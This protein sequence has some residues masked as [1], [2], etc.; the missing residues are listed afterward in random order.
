MK[1]PWGVFSFFKN[2]VSLIKWSAVLCFLFLISQITT[3]SVYKI[4]Q[5]PDIQLPKLKVENAGY[6]FIA[7]QLKL[8]TNIPTRPRSTALEYQAKPEDSISSIAKKF[9]LTPETILFANQK[10]EDKPHN[11]RSD[12]ILIIPPVDGIYY[13]WR[14]DDTLDEVSKKF[15]AQKENIVN[16]TG[17]N[18]DLTT[19]EIKPGTMIM[20]PGGTRDLSNWAS[21]DGGGHPSL[22]IYDCR[23]V[24]SPKPTD[25]IWPKNQHSISGNEYGPSHLGL[26]IQAIEGEPIYA[27]GS[28][29]VMQ[30]ASGWNYGYGNV[31]QID[32][33]NGYVTIYA[34]L[35]VINVRVCTTVNQGTLIG[36]AGST[37]NAPGAHLHF[38]V[39]FGGSNINPYEIIH[40]DTSD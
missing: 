2:H 3:A 12:M 16:F 37:G 30:A 34:H 15:D 10:L 24:K 18:L 14:A 17:N 9:D 5:K 27:A 4:E 40:T 25:L 20:I 31:I 7:R 35:S 22:G 29:I 32:H 13:A 33:G 11:L 23:S 28:G 19:L 39:R 8:K 1:K 21:G 26:D 6:S 36:H 38:E